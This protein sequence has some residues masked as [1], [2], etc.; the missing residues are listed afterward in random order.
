MHTHLAGAHQHRIPSA[1]R[2][3]LT[4]GLLPV[5]LDWWRGQGRPQHGLVMHESFV[6][7][8]VLAGCAID[9]PEL[10][11]AGAHRNVGDIQVA[12]LWRA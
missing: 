3:A 5:G 6:G 2:V 10:I 12:T 1:T 11:P 7:V 4:G 8:A 9:A